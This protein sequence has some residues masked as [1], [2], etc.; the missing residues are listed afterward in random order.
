[1][2]QILAVA[3]S[4][5]A[6]EPTAWSRRSTAHN[7]SGKQQCPSIAGPDLPRTARRFY[8]LNCLHGFNFIFVCFLM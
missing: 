3:L 4:H 8:E 5:C 7:R 2:E 1:G 6:A